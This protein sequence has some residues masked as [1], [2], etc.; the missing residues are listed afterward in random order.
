MR[1]FTFI[2][3]LILFFSAPCFSQWLDN[4]NKFKDSLHMPVSAVT[5]NQARPIVVQG[6]DDGYFVFWEDERNHPTTKRD[7]YAQ[8]YDKDGR[9][10]WAANGVPVAN[11]TNDEFW[12]SESFGNYR[13]YSLAAPDGSGGVYVCWNYLLQT[14]NA[15]VYGVAVQ[16]L[17]ADGSKVF[18]ETGAIIS[19]A[20]NEQIGNPQLVS[21]SKGGFFIAYTNFNDVYAFCYKDVGGSLKLYGGSVMNQYGQEVQSTTDCGPQTTVSYYTHAKVQAYMIYPDQQGGC[22][23]IMALHT[24]LDQMYMG[25]NR[26]VRVKKDCQATLLKRAGGD[27]PAQTTIRV[28]NYKK[29]SVVTLYSFTTYTYE[30]SCH[31]V[32]NPNNT[33]IVTITKIENNGYGF[34]PLHLNPKY[35]VDLPQG[36]VLPTGGNINAEIM[37]ASERDAYA[38]NYHLHGY[39]RL[40]EIYDSIPYELCSDL[41]H[42]YEA[43]RPILPDNAIP[44]DTLTGGPDTLIGHVIDRGPTNYF[45]AGSGNKAWVT[46]LGSDAST[47]SVYLQEL[48]LVADGTKKYKFIINTSDKLGLK[49]GQQIYTGSTETNVLYDVPSLA[50]DNNGNGLFYVMES[51]RATRVSPIGDGGVLTWGAMGKPIGSGYWG[52]AVSSAHPMAVLGHDGKGLVVW[53]SDRQLTGTTAQ[54]IW[55][56]RITNVFTPSYQPP[57]NTLTLLTSSSYA[58]AGVYLTGTTDVWT[59]IDGL[60]F[61]DRRFTTPLMSLKDNYPLGILNLLTYENSTA[62]RFTN[63][64]PYLN[65]NFKITVANNPNGSGNIPMRFYIPQVEFDALKTADPGIANPGDLGIIEQSSTNTAVPSAYTPAAGDQMLPLTGW[66]SLDGGYYIE[67]IAKGFSDFFITK[68]VVPLPLKWLDVQGQLTT[69]AAAA[70]SWTVTEEKNVTGYTVQYSSDGA[71][72]IDGC[73]QASTNIGS[74]SSYS[75]TVPLP[76]AGTY[77][78]RVKEK[79]IDGKVSYS[80]II[81]LTA[82][83]AADFSVSPNPATSAAVLRIP[84]AAAVK[85]LILLGISGKAVWQTAGTLSGSVTIPMEQLP[86]GV[87]HL[88]VMEDTKVHVLK[89]V[90]Q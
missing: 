62:T 67:F 58:S 80:K 83:A 22:N 71:N 60:V 30:V 73:A 78:F 44:T 48:K 84:Y 70:I 72:F 79:D 37:S 47:T 36:V 13:R 23:V 85:K 4:S 3:S 45:M 18:G 63:G 5:D 76:G 16:H 53:D 65:R 50:T 66:G 19:S 68:G 90:K 24:G 9:A 31:P 27:D 54:N 61:Q 89:I 88:K 8:K 75:C 33:T 35:Y 21:D 28:K 1:L 40:N 86:A 57:L 34:L 42:P 55:M 2:L 15:N 51:N 26:L 11:S 17:H 82:G 25:Y 74:T 6:E 20:A 52:A 49:I 41:D 46:T 81:S 7:I 29:D 64:I 87:Y 77:L 69:P 38:S 59:T 10:L 39:Y 14:G 56:Q 43:Y 32:S 12:Q